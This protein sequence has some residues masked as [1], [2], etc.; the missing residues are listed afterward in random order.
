MLLTKKVTMIRKYIISTSI[1]LTFNLIFL[2]AQ[3]SYSPY[4]IFGMGQI[5][6]NGFGAS[7]AMGGTGIAFLSKYSLNNLNPASYAGLDS[8][9]FLFEFGSYFKYSNFKSVK[10][11]DTK[12]DGNIRYLSLGFR[13]NKWWAAGLGI[14]P[15]SS[16]NYTILTTEYIEGEL[17]TYNKNYKGNGGIN[18]FYFS[19]SISPNKHI[20]LGVNTS[21]IL[22]SV[23]QSEMVETIKGN[24]GYVLN[25]TNNVNSLALDYGLILNSDIGKWNYS[26]GFTFGNNKNLKTRSNMRFVSSSDTVQLTSTDGNFY[27]PQRIG[28][29]IGISK[30]NN[31]RFGLDYTSEKYSGLEFSNLSLKTR[32]AEKYSVGFE[33]T[34]Q[35][36]IREY[37][38]RTLYYRAGAYYQKSYLIINDTPIDTKAITFGV[39]LPINRKSSFVNI[40]AELGETGSTQKGLVRERYVM[41]HLNFSLRDI[42]F[43]KPRYD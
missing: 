41:M 30:G 5:M 16:V 18:Q 42:W 10:G 23:Q 8:L 14:A 39:G 7:K 25:R 24:D 22:G 27:L 17:S 1:I 4:T 37:G 31:I 13:F 28:A 12:F 15:Y 26:L 9:T 21:Y 20:A 35:K 19:N 40:S 32:N 6:D 38:L 2:N 3:V 33:Y 29:G 34:P 36:N 43:Q 11:S